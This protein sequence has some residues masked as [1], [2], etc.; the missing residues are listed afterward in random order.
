MRVE[1]RSSAAPR[2]AA[3]TLVALAAVGLGAVAARAQEKP[4]LPST[5]DPRASLKPGIKD[6]GTAAKNMTLVSSMG[7]PNGFFD[8]KNP[9]GDPTPPVPQSRRPRFCSTDMNSR[10]P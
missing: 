3:W 8:P 6:A 5:T 10:W 1:V 7:K 2:R 4:A 9:A